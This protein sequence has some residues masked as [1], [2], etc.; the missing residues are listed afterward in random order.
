MEVELKD[1]KDALDVQKNAWVEFQK[2]NNERL[3]KIE[4]GQGHA[5]LDEKLGKMEEDLNR[6]EGLNSKVEQLE[7]AAKRNFNAGG[8]NKELSEEEVKQKKAMIGYIRT[9]ND[10]DWETSYFC[11]GF[12]PY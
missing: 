3:E 7:A 5:E 6:Y 9:A 11:Y 4:K 2:T 1:L 10:R 12:K 8:E